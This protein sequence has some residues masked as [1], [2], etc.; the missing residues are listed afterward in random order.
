[1]FRV[2]EAPP[3]LGIRIVRQKIVQSGRAMNEDEID[4]VQADKLWSSGSLSPFC[5]IQPVTEA[6]KALVAKQVFPRTSSWDKLKKSILSLRAS[7]SG[8]GGEQGAA[9]IRTS[10]STN[11]LSA[12][13]AGRLT[14]EMGTSSNSAD[15]INQKYLG[16]GDISGR[17]SSDNLVAATSPGEMSASSGY[18][19]ESR[20]L[21][22]MGNAPEGAA[23]EGLTP[24]ELAKEMAEEDEDEEEDDLFYD[25]HIERY[26]GRLTFDDS[27]EEEDE[28]EDDEDDSS[29]PYDEIRASVGTM[30]S[31]DDMEHDIL[32]T[33]IARASGSGN[34]SVSFR[35]HRDKGVVYAPHTAWKGGYCNDVTALIRCSRFA[36]IAQ[37]AEDG[38]P[39]KGEEWSGSWVDVWSAIPQCTEAHL[40]QD[41]SSVISEAQRRID[42]AGDGK[43]GRVEEVT[44]LDSLIPLVRDKGDPTEGKYSSADN[45]RM[46]KQRH[47][48]KTLS[49]DGDGAPG[50]GNGGKY[51]WV[52]QVVQLCDSPMQESRNVMIDEDGDADGLVVVCSIPLV[53]DEVIEKEECS[54]RVRIKSD[55]ST[56]LVSCAL[57]PVI[58][59]HVKADTGEASSTLV[60]NGGGESGV[61]AHSSNMLTVGD[62]RFLWRNRIA[63]FLFTQLLPMLTACAAMFIFLDRSLFYHSG[64]ASP[65]STS[66]VTSF[67]NQSN[68]TCTD[69]S[70]F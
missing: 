35:G 6:E 10:F 32:A 40:S 25:S 20:V 69:V 4:P 1:M 27:E 52:L 66:H 49:G 22:L 67:Q 58:L 34:D 18:N 37:Q 16:G 26:H 12:S 41:C 63:L 43:R 59:A 56:G 28:E 7:A 2:F 45:G 33:V 61:G 60:S 24:E 11:D 5:H 65:T 14:G 31:Q 46:L 48:D 50:G 38:T 68:G 23:L 15:D 64:V 21:W 13:K 47:G 44:D 42:R 51:R 39:Q 8:K 19:V 29:L 30:E 3:T 53:D 9:T 62:H 17:G 54:Y 70:D 55:D 36:H 57:V